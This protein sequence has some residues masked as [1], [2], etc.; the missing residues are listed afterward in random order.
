MLCKWFGRVNNELALAMGLSVSAGRL[1]AFLTFNVNVMVAQKLGFQAAL[2]LGAH[3][4][5]LTH[6]H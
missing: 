2:F 1:G 5:V 4:I 6:A 3:P